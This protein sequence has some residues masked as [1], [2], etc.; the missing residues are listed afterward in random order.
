MLKKLTIVNDFI[1]KLNTHKSASGR[2]H[3]FPR[4]SLIVE[5]RYCMFSNKMI[6]L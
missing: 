3:I 4:E 5:H 1:R 6:E 2:H